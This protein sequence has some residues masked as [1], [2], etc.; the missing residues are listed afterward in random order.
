MMPIKFIEL[1]VVSDSADTSAKVRKGTF[2]ADQVVSFLDVSSDGHHGGTKT[3]IT[4]A[5]ANDYVNDEDETGG[6]VRGQRTI[7]VQESYDDVAALVLAS[8]G[9]GAGQT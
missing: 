5:E 8:T 3:K 2:R 9:D 7:Y 4:L 6:V 1:N